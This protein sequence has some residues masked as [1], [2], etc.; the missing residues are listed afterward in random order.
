MK[1]NTRSDPGFEIKFEWLNTVLRMLPDIHLN[2][3]TAN[4]PDPTSFLNK[5]KSTIYIH[6]LRIL[7][8]RVSGL[9]F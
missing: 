7:Y 5:Q 4:H 6:Y 9:S 2:L 3:A 8:V 1:L